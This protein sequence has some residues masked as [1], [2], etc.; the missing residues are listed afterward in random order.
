MHTSLDA[1]LLTSTKGGRQ[2]S[3]HHAP[4]LTSCC[5]QGLLAFLYAS[6]TTQFKGHT[7]LEVMRPN[8]YS[9]CMIKDKGFGR[10]NR[11]FS[12]LYKPVYDHVREDQA[13]DQ[14]CVYYKHKGILVIPA[15]SLLLTSIINKEEN[16]GS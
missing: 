1:A 4:A 6:L 16:S 2:F 14:R 7:A 9:Q 13:E 5:R 15:A 12:Y 10:Y 11:C 8:R 3:K